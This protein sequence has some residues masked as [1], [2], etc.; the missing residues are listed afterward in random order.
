MSNKRSPSIILIT[1]DTGSGKSEYVASFLHAYVI[2]PLQK[3]SR[4]RKHSWEPPELNAKVE[5]VVLDHLLNLTDAKQQLNAAAEWCADHLKPLWIVLQT[6]RDLKTMK[7]SF[8]HALEIR[9]S[10]ADNDCAYNFATLHDKDGDQLPRNFDL[11]K[12]KEFGMGSKQGGCAR[13]VFVIEP[14]EQ[15]ISRLHGM[16]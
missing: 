12:G 4:N 15:E 10:R 13:L 2:D 1:G 3:Q 16:S 9:I 7:L 8:S 11:E 14:P 6:K 5:I